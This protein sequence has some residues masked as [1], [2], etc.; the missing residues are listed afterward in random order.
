MKFWLLSIK[1]NAH[2]ID[3]LFSLSFEKTIFS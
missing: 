1:S 2:A 3:F